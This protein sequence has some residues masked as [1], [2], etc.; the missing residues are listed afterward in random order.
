MTA[1]FLY[2]GLAPYLCHFDQTGSLGWGE[3]LMALF[4]V[5]FIGRV[6]HQQCWQNGE[7]GQHCK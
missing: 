7:I 6:N 1:Y 5:L 3:V 4:A 2:R